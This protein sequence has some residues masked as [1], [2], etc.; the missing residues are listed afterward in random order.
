MH[1]LVG[2]G[3]IQLQAGGGE[4]GVLG[5]DLR[6]ELAP[7]GGAEEVFEAEPELVGRELPARIHEVRDHRRGQNRWPLDH[8]EMQPDAHARHGARPAHCI[9]RRSTGDHKAGR[10]QYS[11]AVGAF[12]ALVDGFGQPEIVR[13][14]DDACHESKQGQGALPPGPP[15][16]AGPLDA[17][18]L[19]GSL[20]G[21]LSRPCKVS[22]G[23]LSNS[24]TK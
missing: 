23:P 14:D 1:V 21:G 11:F 15:P 19:F 4:G 9:G 10:L 13:G 8:H 18:H 3:V 24:Q 16:K 17:I 2:V 5:A 6:G 22:I 20:K 7:H 12:Y